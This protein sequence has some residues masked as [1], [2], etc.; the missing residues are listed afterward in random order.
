MYQLGVLDAEELSFISKGMM[1]ATPSMLPGIQEDVRRSAESSSTLDGDSL[2]RESFEVDFFEDVRASFQR[3]SKFPNV[4]NA[5]SK[6]I[7]GVSGSKL[8]VSYDFTA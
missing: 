5:N 3:S 6:V 1:K 4:A 7:P 2:T 8:Y